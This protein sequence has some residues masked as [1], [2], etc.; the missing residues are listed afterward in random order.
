MPVSD[1]RR[2]TSSTAAAT[3]ASKPGAARALVARHD[4]GLQIV[5]ARQAARC[6]WCGC[7]PCGLPPRDDPG[8]ELAG[9]MHAYPRPSGGSRIAVRG[10]RAPAVAQLFRRGSATASCQWRL[11]R[12]RH[13]WRHPKERRRAPEPQQTAEER[14]TAPSRK[15]AR[16]AGGRRCAWWRAARPWCRAAAW[17]CRRLPG[18]PWPGSP[19]CAC[20]RRPWRSPRPTGWAPG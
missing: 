5:R 3:R 15:R 1:C 12:G 17:A 19:P 6:G 20:S 10:K 4:H 14:R 2:T 16:A 9:L 11:T 7:V 18:R 8:D 13:P